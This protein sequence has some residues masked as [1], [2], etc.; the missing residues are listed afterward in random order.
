M[1]C[2][3]MARSHFS[4]S[5]NCT[6]IPFIWNSLPA[7][8]TTYQ[9]QCHKMFSTHKMSFVPFVFLNFACFC[10]VIEIVRHINIVCTLT[11]S[12]TI[13]NQFI[14]FDLLTLD[15]LIRSI[16]EHS[17]IIYDTVDVYC[18]YAQHSIKSRIYW[19]WRTAQNINLSVC[20]MVTAKWHFAW[21]S[22]N[23]TKILF[24]Q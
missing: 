21:N 24:V 23:C 7:A 10:F 18:V 14:R 16:I 22:P 19:R 17:N 3:F 2:S 1:S 8:L 9:I 4:T 13:F 6:A 5:Q 11:S 12:P 20:W 15:R